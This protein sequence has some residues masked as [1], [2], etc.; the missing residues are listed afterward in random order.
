MN[1]RIFARLICFSKVRCTLWIYV[2]GIGILQINLILQKFIFT[3]FFINLLF[4]NNNLQKEKIF[5]YLRNSRKEIINYVDNSQKY[6][7]V[8]LTNFVLKK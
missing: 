7:L 5:F 8:D 4:F 1:S 2:I 6:V 3:F